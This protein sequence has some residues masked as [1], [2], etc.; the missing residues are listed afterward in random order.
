MRLRQSQRGVAVI[1]ALLLTTLAL[2]IVAS[3]F[4]Q[5]QVQVRLI[6]NQR[7]QL[8]KQWILRGALDWA[9]LIVREDAKYS[10]IDSL[11]EPWATP[12]AD[13][14]LDQ[15]V[16][17]GKADSDIADTKL[18]GQI[19]DA[20]GRFNLNNLCPNGVI[21]NVA[22]A[23]YARLL[24]LLNADAQLAQKTAQA[25]TL[26]APQNVAPYM[27][28]ANASAPKIMSEG[29]MQRVTA[30]PVTAAPVNL[31]VA[32]SLGNAQT[33]SF[34]QVD[35]LFA[36][37]GYSPALLAKLK[38]FVIFLP[39]SAPVNINTASA[40]VIAALVSNLSLSEAQLLVGTRKTASFN[41]LNSITRRLL[42]KQFA[43]NTFS[44]TSNYFL[45]D[46]KVQMNRARLDM[47]ALLER[48]GAVTKL[49]W[50]REF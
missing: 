31:P 30:I 26:A 13:T 2:T 25:M 28:A 5:Q 9:S 38:T 42:G 7:L 39:R 19:Y 41:D 44:V 27:P 29:I 50:I 43:A 11:D 14:R 3:L 1:M 8:Q 37:A 34:N 20:Q 32:P 21:D 45:I 35:D 48:N 12:L 22:V 4:W 10:S 47:Q 33:M 23:Q 15:Y 40:E 18:A 49:L 46:G 24:T 16:E 36:V 6:E 17:N